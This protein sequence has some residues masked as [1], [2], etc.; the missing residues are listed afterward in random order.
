MTYKELTDYIFSRMQHSD[1]KMSEQV[2][3]DVADMIKGGER[4]IDAAEYL[5]EKCLKEGVG[6]NGSN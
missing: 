6:N 3:D 5:K 1:H 4:R 2:P